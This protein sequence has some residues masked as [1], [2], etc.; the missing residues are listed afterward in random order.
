MQHARLGRSTLGIA[1]TVGVL[2]LLAWLVG[3]A[4]FGLHDGFFHALVP[5]AGVL[6]LFQVVRRVND[7]DVDED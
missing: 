3:W 1:G 6:I 4:A 5:L 2:L 7:H